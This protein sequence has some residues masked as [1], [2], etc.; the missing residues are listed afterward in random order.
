MAAAAT[1]AVPC[2][3]GPT[4]SGEKNFALHPQVLTPAKT[5]IRLTISI[6]L[7]LNLHMYICI[8]MY[9]HLYLCVWFSYLSKLLR[10]SDAC[11]KTAGSFPSTPLSCGGGLPP[12]PQIKLCIK[13]ICSSPQNPWSGLQALRPKFQP[14]CL[15][16]LA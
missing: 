2:G 14:L 6:Y 4:W 3:R 9:V 7:Y 5:R 12:K 10:D 1:R 15:A 11:Q 13:K 16:T 8:Y